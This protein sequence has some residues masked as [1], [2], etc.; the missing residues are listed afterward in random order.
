MQF[1]DFEC[2][3]FDCY[4]TLIDWEVG[5]AGALGPLLSG[6]GIE[7]DDEE[8]LALYAEIEP[9]QQEGEFRLY[10]DILGSVVDAIGERLG[11]TPSSSE[12]AS[13]ADSI[14]DWRPFPDTVGS[15]QALSRRFELV[16]ISNIDDDLF[17]QSAGRLSVPFD[18]VVTAEQ[19]RAYKPSHG[20]FHLAFER[21]GRGP[22]GVLHV[23]QSLYHDIAPA[24]ELGLRSV[25]VNRKAGR[26]GSGAT[27]PS[28]AQPDLEVPDLAT[29]VQLIGIDA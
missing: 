18:H 1:D 22:K 14:A 23:A 12:R 27:A 4:G 9:A 19:S 29:L 25:W 10:R 16:I 6:H 3:S 11:F 17:A 28:T 8:V 2:L 7:L 5:I 24:N 26:H 21:M 15:L 20:S 13:L